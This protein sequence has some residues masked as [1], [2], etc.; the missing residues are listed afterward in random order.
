MKMD[1]KQVWEAWI[2]LA[3]Y[4]IKERAVVNTGMKVWTA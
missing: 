2:D 3:Q 1:L 4:I